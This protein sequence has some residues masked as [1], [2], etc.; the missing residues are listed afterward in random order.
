[1]GPVAG[2]KKQGKVAHLSQ[3]CLG[4]SGEYSSDKLGLGLNEAAR[5]EEQEDSPV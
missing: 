5:D 3:R 4:P 2:K 1:M